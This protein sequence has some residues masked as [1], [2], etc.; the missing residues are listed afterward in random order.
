MTVMQLNAEIYESL[1]IIANDE[2]LLRKAAKSLKRLASQF[3]DQTLMTKDEFFA[4]VDKS[5][6]E[7]KEGKVKRIATPT[8][9]ASVLES[10]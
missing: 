4:V 3:E 5:L 9:L 8:E 7:A 6:E 2:S 10:L 1:S